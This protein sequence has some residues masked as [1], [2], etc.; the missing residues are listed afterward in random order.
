MYADIRAC[1]KGR[2]K[3]TWQKKGMMVTYTRVTIPSMWLL[4]GIICVCPRS[5]SFSLCVSVSFTLFF[6]LFLFAS[7]LCHVVEFSHSAIY[8]LK[9]SVSLHLFLQIY[10]VNF[11]FSS[12]FLYFVFCYVTVYSFLIL[13][14]LLWINHM[15]NWYRLIIYYYDYKFF[16]CKN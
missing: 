9:F 1:T 7:F 8:F 16:I 4:T 11:S 6:L 13:I 5:W 15:C 14:A 12:L 2:R 3:R 10:F